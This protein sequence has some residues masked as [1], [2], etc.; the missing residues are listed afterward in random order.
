ML[1]VTPAWTRARASS[2]QS[3]WE[4]LRPQSSGRSQASLT[5]CTATSGGKARGAPQASFLS[6]PSEA[7]LAVT[8]A[9]LRDHARR[10][11]DTAGHIGQG[12]A[13]SAQQDHPRPPCEACGDRCAPLYGLQFV[14][15]CR[16]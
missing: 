1:S 3:H 10:H 6:L 2:V 4:R 16:C 12:E 9:P 8:F 13:V 14:T 7:L 5:R 11:L 15:F